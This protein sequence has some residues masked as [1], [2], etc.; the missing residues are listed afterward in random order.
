MPV[1][2]LVRI[3]GLLACL[4]V[5]SPYGHGEEKASPLEGVWQGKRNLA[6]PVR[7]RI[8]VTRHASDWRVQVGPYD[9]VVP[10]AVATKDGDIAFELPDGHGNFNGR[11]EQGGKLLRGFWAQKTG[12]VISPVLLHARGKEQWVGEIVP[13]E[14]EWTAYLVI[15]RKPDGTLTAFLRNPENNSGIFWQLDGVEVKGDRVS[16]LC[17]PPCQGNKNFEGQYD[18]ERKRLTVDFPDRGGSYSLVPVTDDATPGFYARGKNPPPYVYLP[19]TWDDD[20]WKIGTLEEVGMQSEPIAELVKTVSMTPTSLHDPD[21]HAILIA[22]H[23][24]LVVEEY[25]HGYERYKPHD[26]RSATK[27]IASTLVGALMQSGGRLSVSDR[28]YDLIYRD[29]LPEGLDPRKREMTVEHLL[30]MSSGYDCDDWAD[31]QRPGS[32]DTLSEQ[33]DQD[34]YRYTLQLPMEAAPGKVSAYCSVNANLL[35]AVLRAAAKKPVSELFDKLLAQ[36]LQI[37]RYYLG[38]QPSGEPYLAGAMFLLP[39]DFMK[40]GQLM[41][42]GGVWNG[43][44]IV[45]AEYAHQA[46]SPHVMLRGQAANMR[47]GYLWWTTEYEHRGKKLHAYFGSGNGGQEVVAIPELDMVIA[48]YGGSYND[49]GG[50]AMIKDYIPKYIL[51]AVKD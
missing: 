29:K 18:A 27:A 28:V 13:M 5:G 7:G 16:F 10:P 34:F 32:E 41:L 12:G 3:I 44:R 45:S 26:T 9:L 8:L 25:F 2:T 36:P 1:R 21:I 50:W 20:G 43:K 42:D 47:F 51:P 30:T 38:R 24:K 31:T 37:R 11:M 4:L 15:T 23:G 14:N 17:K 6:S 19:P 39:R 48:T 22:R 33:P 49:R 35:G 46:S 40:F